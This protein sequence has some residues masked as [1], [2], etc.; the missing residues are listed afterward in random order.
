MRCKTSTLLAVF[1]MGI[2]LGPLASYE[3]TAAPGAF[4]IEL[5]NRLVKQGLDKRIYQDLFRRA[6]PA[7]TTLSRV[8]VQGKLSTLGI[9]Y[10][11]PGKGLPDVPAVGD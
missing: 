4:E 5:K 7:G 2:A 1:V 6:M 10:D 9:A 8:S 3:A 11:I